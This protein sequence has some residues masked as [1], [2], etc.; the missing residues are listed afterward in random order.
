M[1]ANC[2]YLIKIH[3]SFCKKI[4]FD[5]NRFVIQFAFSIF[6]FFR[7]PMTP[8]SQLTS[9]YD[10]IIQPGWKN[11]SQAHWQSHWEKQLQA[12]R[13]HFEDEDDWIYPKLESWLN[14]LDKQVQACTRPII[15]IAHSLGCATLLHYVQRHPNTIQA[16]LL[17][18]PADVEREN[19]PADLLSFAPL[20]RTIDATT[21]R[22]IASTNDPYCHHKRAEQFAQWWQSSLVYLVGA[23]HINVD[24]GHSEWTVGFDE[25]RLLIDALPQKKGTLCATVTSA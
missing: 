4:P 24:S 13:V 1:A 11:S 6:D 7:F 8:L 21:T 3:I 22:I 12:R 17:V 2:S 15:V 5:L 10:I 14:A 25:L 18:A 20:P 19:A 16:A 23:G 9:T